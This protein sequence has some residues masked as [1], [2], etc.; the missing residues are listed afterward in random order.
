MLRRAPAW[1]LL[2]APTAAFAHVKWFEEY[3]VAQKPVPIGITLSLPSFWLGM[4]LV[5]VLFIVTTILERRQ[6]GLAATRG[7]DT[8]TRPLREH[9][10]VFLVAVLF[11]FFVALFAVGGT[12]LTPELKTDSELI[13]W[14]QLAIALLLIP[15]LT[16]PLAA[17]A[18]VLLWLITMRDYDLFHL[19]DYLALGLGL[20]GYL[21]LSG[22]KDGPWHDRR[23]AVLRWGIAL[24]LMWSSM[25]KFMYPQWFLP[26]L[27]E[28]P[29]LAFGIP[30]GPYTTMAGVAEFTLGFGLLWTPLV[31][32]LS[33]VAL[34]ALMFAAVYPFGRVDMIGHATILAALLV[35]IAEPFPDRR[36]LEVAPLDRRATWW[37]PIGLAIALAVTMISY[38][39]Q[40][41]LIYERASGQLA[42]LLRPESQRPAAA[43]GGPAPGV[44]W[45]GEHY[46]G[47]VPG[48]TQT[49]ATT[50]MMSAMDRMHA[51]M[52]D[53]RVTGDID[54]D[55]V[56]MMVPH[57]QS[58]V[59]MAEAYL[60]HGRDPELRRLA[61]QII[62]SQHE[63]IR[64]MRSERPET[65][66]AHH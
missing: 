21:L 45:R 43:E 2:L 64:I 42:T 65:G 66:A 60:R 59:D 34:F 63:E 55:F 11:A 23:F 1:L 8:V 15:R 5:L 22:M 53:V 16:R 29:F 48:G 54:R 9:A 44:F 24:A 50:A 30:F 12:Y 47:S 13:P 38:S 26:L 40:H 51:A 7:L 49:E 28:K 52:N 27:E 10:D 14:A 36:A 57:H 33:A 41:Y 62:R 3:E 19:Y 37:V 39:G 61:E 6:P 31:R 4:A 17:V 25:E 46:H 58:A 56:A 18:I 35:I 20:A 32:R